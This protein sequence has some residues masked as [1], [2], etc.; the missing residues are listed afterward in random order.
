ME[1]EEQITVRLYEARCLSIRS[2]SFSFMNKLQQ[3]HENA[4]RS[5]GLF[6]KLDEKLREHQEM[7]NAGL[8]MLRLYC[9]NYTESYLQRSLS[10]LVS[11]HTIIEHLSDP[12][13][14]KEDALTS[15]I[16]ENAK[17]VYVH[18]M[19][20]KIDNNEVFGFLFENTPKSESASDT[21]SD[22]D[23]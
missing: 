1:I 8:Y 16:L 20:V 10:N 3:A 5:S 12:V 7:R 4:V 13:L 9:T 11:A 18:K 22:F 17:K 14:A 23:L 15:K 19:T 6:H 21:D 2:R